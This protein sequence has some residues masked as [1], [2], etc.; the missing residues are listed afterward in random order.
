MRRFD[1]TEIQDFVAQ[2]RFDEQVLFRRDPS[3]PKLTVVTPSFNQAQFLERTILSIL[4]QNYPN[5]EYII[6][7]GGSRDGS[8][9]IIRKYEKYLAYWVSEKDHGQS[10]ALNKGYE[11][12][13]GDIIGWQN[14]DDI[15]LPDAFTKAVR[16]LQGH[17]EAEVVFSNRLDVDEHDNLIGESR[18]TPFS[19]VVYWYDGMCLSNQSTFWRRR[20]FARS[21]MIDPELQVA[22]DYEFFLRAALRGARFHH[23]RDYWGAIRLHSAS[24]QNLH[25]AGKMAAECAIIDARYGRSRVMNIP[26][27]TYSRLRRFLLYCAQGDCDYAFRGIKR[28]AIAA[29]ANRAKH[30]G[31]GTNAQV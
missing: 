16:E 1:F 14:S 24:K 10:D 18:F 27:K 19:T 8:V 7:D 5:L 17:S 26:F 20:M 31:H 11:R 9:D 28:R 3:F 6:I 29:L 22:M 12:A 25:W 30:G 13:T 23:V 4:N 21:G 2:P 15:Y